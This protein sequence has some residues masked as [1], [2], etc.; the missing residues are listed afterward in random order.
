MWSLLWMPL[1]LAQPDAPFPRA[2][3]PLRERRFRGIVGEGPAWGHPP[4]RQGRVSAWIFPDGVIEH[5]LVR[6]GRQI[7]EIRR[8]DAQ[9]QPLT[10]V[11]QGASG[12]ETVVVHQP[13]ET[14]VEVSAWSARQVGPWALRLPPEHVEAR[15]SE[16]GPTDVWSDAFRD[17]LLATC[18]CVIEYRTTAWLDGRPGARYRLRVLDPDRPWTTEA[19]AVP[20]DAGVLVLTARDAAAATATGRAAAALARLE[21]P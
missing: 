17:A 8:Y 12:P 13:D 20:S 21:A 1:A 11:L 4:A 9:G 16:G 10:T 7:A 18:A 15:W 5:A 6:D 2:D 3:Q 14:R 19:W